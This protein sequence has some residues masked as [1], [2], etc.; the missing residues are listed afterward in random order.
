MELKTLA[1]E[2]LDYLAKVRFLSAATVRAYANDFSSFAQWCADSSRDPRNLDS[3]GVRAYLVELRRQKKSPASVNRSL[4][5]LR[6][7]YAFGRERTMLAVNPFEGAGGL[8]RPCSLPSV[9]F[10]EDMDKL[11]EKAEASDDEAGGD[12]DF[13]AARNAALFELMYSTGCRVSEIASLRLGSRAKTSCAAWSPGMERIKIAGKG[14]KE[15]FVFFS[16]E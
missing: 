11:L 10:E 6:G 3:S 5:A 14:G 2:Y 15:R 13:I 8:K 1:R 4:S 12:E 9:L 7:M 16:D